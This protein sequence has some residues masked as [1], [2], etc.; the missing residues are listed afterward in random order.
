M[1]HLCHPDPFANPPPDTR[2]AAASIV[3]SNLGGASGSIPVG[4]AGGASRR[5]LDPAFLI[6]W[7]KSQS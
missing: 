1:Y 4:M 2:A 7:K 6:W 3:S 5:S